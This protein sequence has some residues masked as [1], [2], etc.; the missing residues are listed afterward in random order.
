VTE[1]MLQQ[2]QVSRVETKFPT[3]IKAFPTLENLA[4][5]S[6]STV[7]HAWQG[8]G[9]NRRGKY[10][11]HIAQRIIREF[12]GVI[13]RK[14]AVLE[15]FPGIGPAT[16]GS[17]ITFTYN[18]PQF[19]IETNIRRVFIHH[20]FNDKTEVHDR[21]IMPILKTTFFFDNPREWYYALMDYGTHLAKEVKN[22]NRKSTH[23]S[24]Q[25]TFEGSR[26]Q[27]RSAVLRAVLTSSGMEVDEL[28]SYTSYSDSDVR[29]VLSELSAEKMIMVKKGRIYIFETDE[30]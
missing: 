15:T 12:G 14:P 8:M 20:F 3:F 13:P 29:S 6:L 23:Y 4:Q 10:L 26:R 27:K 9:Y 1:I 25:S 11:H 17:I 24:K 2:T 22:P 16:A 19:F 28:C 21:D 7:L 30:K 5:A 18:T